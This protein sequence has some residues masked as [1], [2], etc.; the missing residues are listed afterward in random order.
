MTSATI[1]LPFDGR[2]QIYDRDKLITA[3]LV[4]IDILGEKKD[5]TARDLIPVKTALHRQHGFDTDSIVYAVGARICVEQGI[6]P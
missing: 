2:T 1:S 4:Y 6:E 5:A 3:L